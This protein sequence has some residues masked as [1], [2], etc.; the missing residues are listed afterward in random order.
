VDALLGGDNR[1][2]DLAELLANEGNTEGFNGDFSTLKNLGPPA[3]FKP[4][5]CELFPVSESVCTAFW[6]SLAYLITGYA[7]MTDLEQ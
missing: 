3:L 2:V 7:T 5:T 6:V 4:Y 1:G